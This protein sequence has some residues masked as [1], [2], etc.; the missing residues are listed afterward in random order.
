MSEII[1]ITDERGTQKT[2]NKK[3]KKEQGGQKL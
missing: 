2:K 3:E 1:E